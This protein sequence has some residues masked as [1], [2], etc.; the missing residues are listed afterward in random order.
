[1]F[2]AK[3]EENTVGLKNDLVFMLKSVKEA[4]EK[5]EAELL[6]K[7]K[8]HCACQIQACWKGKSWR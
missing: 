4:I 7:Y 8:N 2:D 6:L 3:I 5:E 1:M